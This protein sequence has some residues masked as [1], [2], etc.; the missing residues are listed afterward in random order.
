MK[1]I[2]TGITG[3]AGQFLAEHLLAEGDTVRGYSRHGCWPSY[4]PEP[5]RAQIPL[6]AWDVTDAAATCETRDG[7]AS[8]DPDVVYHLAGLSVPEDCGARVPAAVAAA[9]NVGGAAAV[10]D[11]SAALARQPRVLLVSSSHVYDWSQAA[12]GP[13]DENAPLAP[14]NGYGWSKLLAETLA[15]GFARRTGLPTIV[16]RAFQHAGPRQHARLMLASW[17]RQLIRSP[18]APLEIYN[19]TTTIDLSDVRDVVR[20]YRLLAVRGQPGETYNIGSGVGRSTGEVL[21]A[22]LRVAGGE[23]PVVET[24]PGV[25]RDA[26]ADNRRLVACTGWQPQI[27]IEQCVADTFEFWRRHEVD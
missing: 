1:A 6:S 24:R 8:F 26:L 16:A 19:R 27:A 21:E 15:G 10:L 17:C 13:L 22:L 4:T 5:L 11:V 3:F 9:V 20:A 14:R 12:S 18:A 7:L 2:I 25:R 23:R